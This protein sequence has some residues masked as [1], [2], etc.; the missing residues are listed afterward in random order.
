[1]SA[2]I[3][4]AGGMAICGADM[5][6]L[7]IVPATVHARCPIHPEARATSKRLSRMLAAEV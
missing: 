6:V 3:E 5:P 7:D 4:R 1:M 2:V